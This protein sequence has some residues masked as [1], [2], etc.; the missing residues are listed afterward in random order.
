MSGL[1]NQFF[2]S[3]E[4]PM[5][6]VPSQERPAH[7]ALRRLTLLRLKLLFPPGPRR[8]GPLS[9]VSRSP[10]VSTSSP[11]G[12]R[13][14]SRGIP[15]VAGCRPAGSCPGSPCPAGSF[16]S[17]AR[18]SSA[19]TLEVD[20]AGQGWL[21]APPQGP[22]GRGDGGAADRPG[23][24]CPEWVSWR[25][26]RTGF[27][28]TPGLQEL[29]G[30]ANPRRCEIAGGGGAE[31][32]RLGLPGSGRIERIV[33]CQGFVLIV[34]GSEARRGGRDRGRTIAGVGACRSSGASG[35][36]AAA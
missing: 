15:P 19:R 8:H 11:A 14:I 35:W 3:Q 28:G 22:K 29:C 2:P 33:A 6:E 16:T 36:S 7:E 25:E 24:P 31:A 4:R 21:E 1:R 26:R 30:R 34:R 12:H 5:H 17:S 20:R 18:T 23:T 13:G 10:Y 32:K 27:C 9:C